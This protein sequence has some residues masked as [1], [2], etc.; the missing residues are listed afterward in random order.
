MVEIESF[1][2]F[3]DSCFGDS[4]KLSK[5]FQKMITAKTK[6]KLRLLTPKV[7]P[8]RKSKTNP[9]KKAVTKISPGLLKN[10]QI[11]KSKKTK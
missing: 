1:F 6:R 5:M 9:E 3:C 4:K 8:V 2:G 7:V 11:T 10:A